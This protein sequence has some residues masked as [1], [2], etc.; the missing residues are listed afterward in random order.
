MYYLLSSHLGNGLNGGSVLHQQLHHLHSVLLARNVKRSEAILGERERETWRKVA[1]K[2]PC[3]ISVRC[4]FD[5][6]FKYL[7]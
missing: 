2:L 6:N 5:H 4:C 3:V 7:N 1:Q